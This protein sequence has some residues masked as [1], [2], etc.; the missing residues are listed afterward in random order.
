MN[1]REATGMLKL[2]G[3]YVA[4]DRRP[5]LLGMV[6]TERCNL[7]CHYCLS[8]TDP[9]VHFTFAQAQQVLQEAYERGHRALYFTGGEPMLWRDGRATL[10]DVVVF[11]RKLGFLYFQIYTNGTLPFSVAASTYIVTLDGPRV[12]HEQIRPATYDR[13]IQNVR[14]ARQRNIYS[15]MTI[16]RQ[17][18]HAVRE[19]IREVTA[20]KLFRGIWFNIF[21]GTP[22]ER[23]K[24]GLSDEQRRQAL[25]E[26]WKCK[27]DGYPIM[28]S[29]PA[30]EAWRSNLWPRPLSQT[31]I[32]TPHGFWQCCRDV[33]APGV[34]EQCGYTG[35][36][37]LSQIFAG[38]AGSILQAY[39][40]A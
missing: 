36:I 2:A 38:K 4:G 19:Y 28:L 26:I 13:I 39:K 11:A 1:L 10:Q 8:H 35:C 5:L 32:C 7:D 40:M 29:R 33:A 37:E 22:Q 27:S 18:Y 34:C 6:I 21:T 24:L 20:T 9:S 17:N 3:R 25:D 14:D 31:E 15:S 30:Y 12:V 16:C 23:E